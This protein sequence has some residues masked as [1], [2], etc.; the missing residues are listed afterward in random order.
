MEFKILRK[1]V[2]SSIESRFNKTVEN[3]N[4][5][6]GLNK[7]MGYYGK[8]YIKN[9]KEK[10]IKFLEGRKQKEISEELHKIK[11]V[12]EADD[13]KGD[14]IITLE[15]KK[16]Y[17]WGSNPTAY[18]NYG[19]NGES[20]SG[21]G[22]CKT[23]TATAQAI[24]SHNP[25]L[26]LLYTKEEKRLRKINKVDRCD[27]IGYGSGYHTLPKFEGGVGISSHERIIEGLGLNM[28]TITN[29]SQTDV[30]LISKK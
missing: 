28:K 6:E 15:W 25:I 30:Y 24:N 11:C 26:K 8:E 21:C 9:P 5:E 29:T 16:S 23:S 10:F 12:E 18:T 4:T 22:Y 27:F 13:F 3:L 2:L 19:F 20:I 14:F 7:E 1:A 17:M